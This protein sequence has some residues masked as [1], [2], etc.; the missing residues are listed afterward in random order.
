MLTFEPGKLFAD[1]SLRFD[2]QVVLTGCTTIIS[3]TEQL[4]TVSNEAICTW[5][6]SYVRHLLIIIHFLYYY[7]KTK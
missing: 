4:Y 7:W 6:I 3:P 1:L 2:M 5:A